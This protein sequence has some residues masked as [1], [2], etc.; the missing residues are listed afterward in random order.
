[1]LSLNVIRKTEAT[2]ARREI[3]KDMSFE[4]KKYCQLRIVAVN[5][6]HN[7]SSR[8]YNKIPWFP[9]RLVLL[10]HS[11]EITH[12]YGP[13]K[14]IVSVNNSVACNHLFEFFWGVRGNYGTIMISI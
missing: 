10:P 9:S 1:M 5:A 6:D 7:I 3:R 2:I 13:R 14:K 12:Y 4:D 11:L 8:R